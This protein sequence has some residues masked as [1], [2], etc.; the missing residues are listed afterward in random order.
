[1]YNGNKEKALEH[2]KDFEKISAKYPYKKDLE[3]DVELMEMALE[4][5]KKCEK[6]S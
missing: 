3:S 1:L 6:A 4:K 2:K 5:F